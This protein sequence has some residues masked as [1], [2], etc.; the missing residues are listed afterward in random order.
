MFFSVY[1]LIDDVCVC[2]LFVCVCVVCLFV[3]LCVCVCV[4]VC[5]CDEWWWCVSVLAS[6]CFEL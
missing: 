6:V 4:C 2:V 1:W 3:C 5:V